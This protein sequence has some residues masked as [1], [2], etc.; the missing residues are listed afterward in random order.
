MCQDEPS[1]DN[2]GIPSRRRAAAPDIVKAG[3]YV[4]REPSFFISPA[5]R[6]PQLALPTH[7]FLA[8]LRKKSLAVQFEIVWNIHTCYK[9]RNSGIS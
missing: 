5:P 1:L 8:P 3:L 4:I 7:L 9:I 6:A 2:D